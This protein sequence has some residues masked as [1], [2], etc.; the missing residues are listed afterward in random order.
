MKPFGNRAVGAFVLLCLPLVLSSCDRMESR[1]NTS[2]P[3][4]NPPPAQAIQTNVVPQSSANGASAPT[5]S[6]NAAGGAA[7]PSQQVVVNETF[8]ENAAPDN[9]YNNV[10]LD[11]LKASPT[12]LPNATWHLASGDGAYEAYVTP[13]LANPGACFHNIASAGLSL[14]SAGGY[15]KPTV[16]TISAEMGIAGDS[17]DGY[18]LLG[19]YSALPGG[20]TYNPTANFTGL[21]L[22]RDGSLELIEKGK[23]SQSGVKFTGTF[24]PSVPVK[25]AYSIDTQKGTITN[26]SLVGSSSVY[27]FTTNAFTDSATA[28]AGIGGVTGGNGFCYYTSLQVTQGIVPVAPGPQDSSQT[29]SP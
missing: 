12:N 22:Q 2:P 21:S 17:P 24:D 28:F 7:A 27:T 15:V 14:A 1:S 13:V 26:V 18:C 20:K 16:M 25:L 6:T 19:F 10:G 23:A 3:Q 29:N 5:L 4:A 8:Q 9:Y 11:G